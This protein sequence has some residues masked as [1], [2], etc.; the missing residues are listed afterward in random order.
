MK[1]SRSPRLPGAPGVIGRRGVVGGIALGVGALSL[2]EYESLTGRWDHERAAPTTARERYK[3]SLASLHEP[4]MTMLHI[5]HSTHLFLMGE[6]RILT[7]P[8]FSDPAFG[9]LRHERGPAVG[10]EDLGPLDII[11]IT[12]DHP[13]HADL[14]AMDRMDKRAHVVVNGGDLAAKVR[15]RG[16][17]EVTVLAPWEH[18]QV[19][20]V[21]VIAVPAE[22]DVPEVGYVFNVVATAPMGVYFAGDTRL[23]S[24]L[25]EI[26]E[27]YMPLAAILPVDGTRVRGEPLVTMR[28]ED[29]VVAAKRLGV[30]SVAPS[31]ADAFV[32]DPLAR[33]AFVDSVENARSKFTTLMKQELPDVFVVSPE[34]GERVA[35]WS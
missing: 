31:H 24:G 10:P 15:A 17:R 20:D 13:D 35:L 25:E 28:P 30:R 22:H 1:A 3:K 19:K 29:A 7:D 12:H 2:M 4:A 9:A 34:P 16:F 32:R 14:A 18:I 26:R 8:W 21:A 11:A 33:V 27:R 6:L 5:G 23:H